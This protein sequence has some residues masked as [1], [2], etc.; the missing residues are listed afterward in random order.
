M[1]LK[2][3]VFYWLPVL[4][5]MS[6]IYYLSDQPNLR[7]REDQWD[8]LLR[9]LAHMFFY[10]VLFFLTYRAF[11]YKHMKVAFALSIGYA[12]SDE[13]HQR[14]VPSRHGDPFDIVFDT[15]GMIVVAILWKLQ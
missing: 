10:G 1:M 12:F 11:G 7:I 6:V 13:I 9:K 14:Y 5:W 8:F 4:V 3:F 2:R 15:A